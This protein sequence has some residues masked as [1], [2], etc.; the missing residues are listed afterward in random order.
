MTYKKEA[1]NK[2]QYLVTASI[3]R[4]YSHGWETGTSIKLLEFKGTDISELKREASKQIEQY[5]DY[6]SEINFYKIV[7]EWQLIDTQ[8]SCDDY[9]RLPHEVEII[10]KKERLEKYLKLKEEFENE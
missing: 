1:D 4:D 9:G 7:P 5:G 2:L 3:H 10:Q 6:R 8:V